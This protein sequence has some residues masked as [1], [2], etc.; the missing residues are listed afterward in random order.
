MTNEQLAAKGL[1]LEQ[2]EQQFKVYE[3]AARAQGQPLPEPP[4][5]Q[6]TLSD[7][8]VDGNKASATAKVTSKGQTETT[9]QRFQRENGKWKV[10]N[11]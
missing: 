4:R 9:V 2:A 6:V 8:R 3:E 7:V 1:T 10:C 5:A 11:A